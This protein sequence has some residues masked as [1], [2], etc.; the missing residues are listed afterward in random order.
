MSRFIFALLT[1]YYAVQLPSTIDMKPKF[2]ISLYKADGTQ[3]VVGT[4]KRV[5]W[6][7]V[8]FGNE[9][10]DK[11]YEA[12]FLYLQSKTPISVHKQITFS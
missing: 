4:T 11:Q 9:Y 8:S 7:E 12:H 10:M 2:T 3:Q 6:E 5:I 1:L